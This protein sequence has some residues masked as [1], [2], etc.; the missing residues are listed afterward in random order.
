MK[1]RVIDP[2]VETPNTLIE[3]DVSVAGG[4]VLDIT[5]RIKPINETISDLHDTPPPVADLAKAR[6]RRKVANSFRSYG[7]V[8]LPDRP[9]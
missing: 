2:S 5:A 6:R 1:N 3:R 7:R 9:V 4:K 8:L